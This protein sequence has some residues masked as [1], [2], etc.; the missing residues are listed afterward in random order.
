MPRHPVDK[1]LNKH[2]SLNHLNMQKV[3]SHVQRE[4]GPWL[5]NTIMLEGSDVPFR[6]KRK[7]AYRNLTG[8]RVNLTYYA[9]AE[10]VAGIEFEVM[11]VVRIRQA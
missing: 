7:K 6:F 8:A 10:D 9:T 5:V 3:R 4:Q 11:N 2:A 1:L